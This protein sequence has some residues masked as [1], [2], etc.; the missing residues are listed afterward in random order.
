M[1]G[2]SKGEKI[3]VF[4]LIKLDLMQATLVW[5]FSKIENN[6]QGYKR[7]P[8]ISLSTL[9]QSLTTTTGDT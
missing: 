5:R 4:W 9:L 8:R 7:A 2:I 3:F 1:E 6:I